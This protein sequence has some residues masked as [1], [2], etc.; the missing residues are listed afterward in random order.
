[1]INVTCM[2]PFRSYVLWMPKSSHSVCLG[3]DLTAPPEALGD[4]FILADGKSAA[5]YPLV[6]HLTLSEFFSVLTICIRSCVN[7]TL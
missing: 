7:S 1:V 3:M 4:K 2:S 5:G 6:R